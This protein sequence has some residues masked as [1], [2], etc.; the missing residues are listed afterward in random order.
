MS[1]ISISHLH[2][3]YGRRKILEDISLSVP[4]GSIFGFVGP[5]G[6][7]KTTTI[8]C[9]TGLLHARE[10]ALA[11]FGM[12]L[13]SKRTDIL[14]RTGV[15][16]EE[17]SLYGHLSASEN[18]NICLRLKGRKAASIPGLLQTVGLA[19]DAHR[20]VRQFSSGMKQRLAL[21]LA[22]AGEPELLIL[23]EPVNGLDPAGIIEIRQLL[24]NLNREKGVT[25]FI[26]S[27]I[28][29]EIE[30]L[31][32]HV[33]VIHKGQI[34]Y[35]GS[36]QQLVSR[37]GGNVDVRLET[38]DNLR[39]AAILDKPVNEG[40]PSGFLELSVSSREDI[41]RA[42]SLLVQSGIQVY[43]VHTESR[44]LETSFLEIIQY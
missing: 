12:E 39:A 29:G 22:L 14:S 11:L 17:P 28:L 36:M 15:M 6:A 1:L 2:F 25:I 44:D 18:L 4:A 40:H 41:A 21:A 23:D 35:Q 38:S 19:K 27:H 10:G 24:Q 42:V 13:R 32:D 34:L 7:G 9:L 31:C 8:K 37:R 20:P 3:S 43:E 33:A 16:V 5:N 26:S 30:K